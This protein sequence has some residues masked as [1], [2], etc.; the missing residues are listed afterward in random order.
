MNNKA[1][2]GS[3]FNAHE[4]DA[5]NVGYRIGKA[6]RDA[7]EFMGSAHTSGF[8]GRN[9]A[10]FGEGLEDG[11]SNIV[12]SDAAEPICLEIGNWKLNDFANW[13]GTGV[14]IV[15]FWPPNTCNNSVSLAHIS[16]QN[17]PISGRISQTVNLS[18]LTEYKT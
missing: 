18:E 4:Q 10:V 2:D 6:R 11:Y 9:R 15:G 16:N 13:K 1:R 5:Y 17:M 12:W 3:L 8:R 7:A 14:Q